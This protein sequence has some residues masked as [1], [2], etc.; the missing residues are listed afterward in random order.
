MWKMSLMLLRLPKQMQL[1]RELLPYRSP[2]ANDKPVRTM[3]RMTF[4][5]ISGNGFRLNGIAT[6]GNE[7]FSSD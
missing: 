1:G 5:N 3:T 4:S 6:R 7:G 2:S